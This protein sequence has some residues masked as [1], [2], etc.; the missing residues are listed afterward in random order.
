SSVYG[1]AVTLTAAVRA[2]NPA[3][4]TPT[5]DVDFLDTATG[6]DLG[7]VPLSSGVASLT[8]ATLAAG[9]HA[10][11]AHYLGDGNFAFSLDSEMQTVSQAPLT[12]PDNQTKLSGATVALSPPYTGFVLGQ[13]FS[14]AGISGAPSLSTTAT[15]TS[16][17]GSYPIT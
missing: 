16:L 4:G 1:Q 11:T 9:T 15:A 5:G 3:D 8:T 13:N 12:V 6:A 10:I 2:A 14:P 17:V 7:T